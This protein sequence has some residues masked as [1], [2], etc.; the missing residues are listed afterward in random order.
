MK[1]REKEEMNIYLVNILTGICTIIFGYLIGSIPNGVVIGK[2]FFHKDPRDFG[3]G[4]SGGSNSGR[5]LGKWVGILVTVLD[6]LKTAIVVYAI[7]AVVTFTPLHDY[8]IFSESTL[9]DFTSFYYWLGAIAVAVGH[10]WPVYIHFKG[11]KAVAC[12]MGAAAFTS[13]Y[14]FLLGGVYLSVL[15][16]KKIISLSSLIGAL[17]ETLGAWILF[18]IQMTTNFDIRFFMYTYALGNQSMVYGLWFAIA[19]TII[20]AILVIRHSSN[21]KRLKDGNERTLSSK[22]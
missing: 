15:G 3:S 7:W 6:M 11:G 4:N 14:C 12:F 9:G 2:V 8:Y 16:S 20:Y 18:I 5:I 13:W 19:L 10:C 22:S 21:I 17:A 1:A